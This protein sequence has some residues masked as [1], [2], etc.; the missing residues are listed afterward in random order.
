MTGAG[1]VVVIDG[2]VGA[3][4]SVIV[5]GVTGGSV[6]AGAGVVVADDVTPL[7]VGCTIFPLGPTILPLES[8]VV[9]VDGIVDDCGGEGGVGILVGG[10]GGVP[11]ELP[12]D[13]LGG[14]VPTSKCSVTRVIVKIKASISITPIVLF[15][16]KATYAKIAKTTLAIY[17]FPRTPRIALGGECEKNTI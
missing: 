15:L 6:I 4:G 16:H 7:P 14:V 11:V 8:I 12:V 3:V 17:T 1:G 9:P 13:E 10:V 5:D 2:R